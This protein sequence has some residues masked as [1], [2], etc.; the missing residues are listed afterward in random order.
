MRPCE[1]AAKGLPGRRAARAPPCCPPTRPRARERAAGARPPHL[2]Q[3]RPD[4][5]AVLADARPDV[6]LGGLVAREGAYHAAARE[7]ARRLQ[8]RPLLG[9]VEVGRRAPAAEEEQAGRDA[10]ACAGGVGLG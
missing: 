5:R 9:E 7:R 2:L 8:R 6:H 10:L 1:A 4:A 3:Q